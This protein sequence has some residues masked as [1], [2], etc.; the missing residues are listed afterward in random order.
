MQPR[1]QTRE[2]EAREIEEYRPLSRLSMP[3]APQGI[4]Y[5][6]VR[7]AIH[8]KDD[9]TN[10]NKRM[11]DGWTFVKKEEHPEYIGPAYA[12]GRFAGIIGSGDLALMKNTFAR[13]EGRRR[14]YGSR[15]ES[16][17]I[18]VDNSLMKEGAASNTPI[19]RQSRSEVSKSQPKGRRMVAFDD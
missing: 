16:Q 11:Q 14:Y 4:E 8:D 2:E 18:G 1:R 15:N 19:I 6:W 5:H 9:G 10:L 12:E 17:M 13:N 7:V 3:V